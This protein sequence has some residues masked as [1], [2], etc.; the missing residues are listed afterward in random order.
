MSWFKTI[1][2]LSVLGM[3][4]VECDRRPEDHSH[5]YPA[6]TLEAVSTNA[7]LSSPELDA[8]VRPG[9]RTP[10]KLARAS[11]NDR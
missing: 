10:F 3:T 4:W 2:L 7:W 9:W 11:V 1:L 8:A 5:A 6:A